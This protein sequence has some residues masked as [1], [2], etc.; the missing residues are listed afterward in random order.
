MGCIAL[1][2]ALTASIATLLIACGSGALGSAWQ[3]GE[4]TDPLTDAVVYSASTVVAADAGGF[5]MEVAMNCAV[6]D[7][8]ST[9]ETVLTFFMPDD[10]PAPLR[11]TGFGP[12][13]V[14]GIQMRLDD[15]PPQQLFASNLAFNNQARLLIT[16]TGVDQLPT[17]QRVV[18]SPNLDNGNPVFV[19]DISDANARRVLQQCASQF[20]DLQP[21][22]TPVPEEAQNSAPSPAP[23]PAGGYAG[24]GATLDPATVQAWITEMRSSGGGEQAVAALRENQSIGAQPWRQDYTS[25]YVFR[26]PTVFLN[27]QVFAVEIEGS[28]VN[29]IGCCRRPH[30][31]LFLRPGGDVNQLKAFASRNSC[32]ARAAEYTQDN[33]IAAYRDAGMP[34]SDIRGEAILLDCP[35]E[36]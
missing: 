6:L 3:Y 19:F 23:L 21:A 18:I 4:R 35:L 1:R 16:T 13:G 30:M 20:P 32:E 31:G 14:A 25:I 28:G 11:V 8:A 33:L 7:G 5:K 26:Q 36:L 17:V 10:E 12:M 22:A 9:F 34:A 27:H 15:A 2:A 29:D 24:V